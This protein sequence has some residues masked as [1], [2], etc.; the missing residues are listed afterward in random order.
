MKQ[1]HVFFA[2]HVQGVGFRATTEEIA[3]RL[4]VNGWVRNRRDGRVEVVAAGEET[5]LQAFLN[6]VSGGVLASHIRE[7]EVEWSEAEEEY[8]GFRVRATV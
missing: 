2:G 8:S 6:E 1:L 7:R 3:R 5:Q 4:K